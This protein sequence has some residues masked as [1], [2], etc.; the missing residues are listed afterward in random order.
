MPK[1]KLSGG[2]ILDPIKRFING[3]RDHAP[4]SVRNKLKEIGGDRIIWLQAARIPL[5][6]AIAALGNYL[7]HGELDRE[8]ERQGYESIYHLSL[9]ITLE[10]ELSYRLEKAHTISLT[11]YKPIYGEELIDI[12]MNSK[13]KLTLRTMIANGE[14]Y[15]GLEA[16]YKY[17]PFDTNCQNFVDAI[18]KSNDQTLDSTKEIDTFVRQDS[19]KFKEALGPTGTKI[20]ENATDLA[21]RVDRAVHGDGIRHI[22]LDKNNHIM[23]YHAVDN[24]RKRHKALS[25]A[26]ANGISA[27]TLSRRLLAISNLNIRRAPELSKLFKKDRDWLVGR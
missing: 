15:E 26:I 3:Q 25:E 17:R 11:N 16:F 24:I 2:D 8:R 13:K 20:A 10:N 18:I 27:E 7:S 12:P 23:N 1:Q 5:P 9:I 21:A 4:P 6:E 19:Q 22:I 14:S